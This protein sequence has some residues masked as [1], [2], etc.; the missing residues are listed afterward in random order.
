MA[1]R[2]EVKVYIK[3]GNRQMFKDSGNIDLVK[4]TRKKIRDFFKLGVYRGYKDRY[5]RYILYN[6]FLDTQTKV[7]TNR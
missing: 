7:P 5:S 1:I 6:S 2:M 3:V 4:R